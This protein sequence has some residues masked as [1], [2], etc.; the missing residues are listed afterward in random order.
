MNVPQK[1]KTDLPYDPAMPLLRIDPK[2]SKSKCYIQ[3][4]YGTNYNSQ[5]MKQPSCP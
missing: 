3:A 4:Y 1:L 2:K 5:V